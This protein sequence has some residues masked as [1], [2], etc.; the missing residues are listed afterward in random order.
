MNRSARLEAIVGLLVE[1]IAERVTARVSAEAPRQVEG[2]IGVAE[3]ARRTG[4]SEETIRDRIKAGKL[5]AVR[6]PGSRGYKIRPEDLERFM[7]GAVQAVASPVLP[8]APP[9]DLTAERT[10]R[11]V[12]SIVKKGSRE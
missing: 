5:P 12:D 9:A 10:R 7:G 8:P 4:D 1:E 3:A 6:P 2:Y 11:I